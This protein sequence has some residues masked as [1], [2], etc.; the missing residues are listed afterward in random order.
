MS[1]TIE[2][3]ILCGSE[4]GD[5][6]SQRSR[7]ACRSA[8]RQ[9]APRSALLRNLEANGWTLAALSQSVPD[10]RAALKVAID[11][12]VFVAHEKG[13]TYLDDD[14]W[15]AIA[16][17]VGATPGTRGWLHIE[18]AAAILTTLTDSRSETPPSC[19]CECHIPG[20]DMDPAECD[21]CTGMSEQER[22]AA[23]S[24]TPV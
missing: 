22:N 4:T 23:R 5:G 6:S 1:H 11:G 19:D 2:A 16:A 15:E 21:N 10:L 20:T 3:C 18:A 8:E 14:A 7:P 13:Q 12:L 24:E 9:R 17:G